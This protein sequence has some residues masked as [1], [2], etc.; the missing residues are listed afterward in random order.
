MWLLLCLVLVSLIYQFFRRFSHRRRRR[1]DGHDLLDVELELIVLTQRDA[2]LAA[3]L[4]LT[5]QQCLAQ[6][7]TLTFL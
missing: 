6:P 4:D 7:Y 1:G 5:A 3:W 2:Y